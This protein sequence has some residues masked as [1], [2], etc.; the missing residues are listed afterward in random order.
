[1]KGGGPLAITRTYRKGKK[2]NVKPHR[3]IISAKLP[4][5]FES[6]V[7][8]TNRS[9]AQR[10]FDAINDPSFK[11]GLLPSG[12]LWDSFTGSE[13]VFTHG[14]HSPAG[15]H[16]NTIELTKTFKGNLSDRDPLVITPGD[17]LKE[18]EAIIPYGYDEETDLYLPFGFTDREGNLIITELPEATE[19][20]I[21][22]E[23]PNPDERGKGFWRSIKLF[24]EKV[25]WS[26][27][28]GRHE[29]HT[30]SLIRP[31]G[32][33]TDKVKYHGRDKE[34]VEREKISESIKK[35]TEEGKDVLLLIHG[36]IGDTDDM[37]EAIF[38]NT[39]LHQRFGTVLA[40]D[41]EN[42]NTPIDEAA[43]ALLKLL[44]E[45]GAEQKQLIIIAQSMGG[46]V[47]RWMIEREN[48]DALVKQL[49]QSGTPNGGSKL[50]DLRKKFT[51]WFALGMNGLVFI[52]PH[53]PFFACIGM[54]LEK[55]IFRSLDQLDPE[56][57][58][59]DKL[60]GN[61]QNKDIPYYLLAGD[62]KK[63]EANFDDT[64]PIVKKLQSCLWGRSKYILGD[65]LHSDDP[66]DLVVQQSS[67]MA[68]PWKWEPTN[69]FYPKCDHMQ[70]YT[71][72]ESLGYIESIFKK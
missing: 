32:K 24:G 2:Y 41:Y 48:G 42:L 25:V 69:V 67:M 27:L 72:K 26:R 56:S 8:L 63:I 6:L 12:T 35:S 5:N 7:Q 60:N 58:F 44:K 22:G 49:I 71:S 68:L 34:Q 9:S 53:M 16:L 66:N 37:V 43:Q 3:E 21:G 54:G 59:L 23:M 46:L 4:N 11:R 14:L 70:Y 40:F 65:F 18:D 45:C 47:A 28:S 17:P 38:E 20:V 31:N 1:M 50:A 10:R 64:D 51:G 62:T 30:L 39:D 29:Y 52:Q 33:T 57:S 15:T 13:S 36:I 19:G 61:P 55:L